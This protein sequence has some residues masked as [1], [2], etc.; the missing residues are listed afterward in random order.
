RVRGRRR[1]HHV[2]RGGAGHD[3][4]R[5]NPAPG[6]RRHAQPAHRP[7]RHQALRHEHRHVRRHPLPLQ[8]RRRVDHRPG[9][10]PQ[11]RLHLPL[12]MSRADPDPSRRP[13]WPGTTGPAV[14]TPR[15]APGSVRRTTAVDMTYPNGADWLVLRGT[16]RDLRT[17][18]DGTT[19]VL[20]TASI[21]VVVDVSGAP[22][23]EAASIPELIGLPAIA[24]FRRPLITEL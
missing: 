2:Q 16:G 14:G 20:D 19:E 18:D 5:G 6:A 8:R 17:D 7:E 21:E 15:R 1:R 13:L 9:A 3:P 10:E 24:G 12:L 11:R 22:K 23:I 4:E